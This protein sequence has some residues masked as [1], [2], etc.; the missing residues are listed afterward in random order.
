MQ[1]ANPT[2]YY[3]I[4]AVV[5]VAIIVIAILASGRARSRRLQQ[6][7]GP[8]YDR[9]VRTTGDRAVAER[10]LAARE[11]RVRRMHIEEL[12]AGARDRYTEEWRTVQTRFVDQPREALKEAD[13]LVTN[14]M[15]DRGYPMSDFE[16]RAADISPDHP[17]VVDNY[18]IAHGIASRSTSGEVSTEDLRQ[19]MVH[20]RTLFNDLLGTSDERKNGQ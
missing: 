3:V 14:V 10:D 13:D 19:A 11:T 20:Y 1:A 12:P 9:A 5:V 4:G 7:F 8:E 18:R 2:I 16:Q 17:Q 15:R 6:R